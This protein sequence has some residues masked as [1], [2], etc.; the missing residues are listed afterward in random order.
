MEHCS[1]HYFPNAKLGKNVTI[2]GKMVMRINTPIKGKK[3]GIH[4][5]AILNVES[6]LILLRMNRLTPNGGVSKPIIRLRT[7]TRPKCRGSMPTLVS[8][9]ARTGIRMLMAAMVSIKQPMNNKKTLRI[10]S[11]TS[12]LVLISVNNSNKTIGVR[13][14]IKTQP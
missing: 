3:N 8:N 9:G 6:P 13:L 10:K 1:T 11:T 5:L 14:R 2:G 4:A 7:M 12:G